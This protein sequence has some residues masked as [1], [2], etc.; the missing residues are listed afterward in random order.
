MKCNECKTLTLCINNKINPGG[1]IGDSYLESTD[2]FPPLPA[3]DRPD[4]LENLGPQISKLIEEVYKSI[5]YSLLCVA[6]T[7]IRTVLDRIITDKIGDCGSFENKTEK[8]VKNGLIDSDEKELLLAVID[9]G[10]ASAHR[11]FD[12]DESII[13]S[14]VDIMEKIIYKICI[15]PVNK[16]ELKRKADLLREK[17]PKRK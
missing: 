7:G 2:Y 14:M 11:G 8:V 15:I 17:T 12:P 6:S 1:M 4:W 16:K 3:R 13:N 5:D 10:S 9:T